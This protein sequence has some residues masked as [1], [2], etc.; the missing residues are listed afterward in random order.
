MYDCTMLQVITVRLLEHD[1][2]LAVLCSAVLLPQELMSSISQSAGE[3][4]PARALLHL[5]C[6]AQ[7]TSTDL[8]NRPIT[9]HYG[10]FLASFS[11]SRALFLVREVTQDYYSLPVTYNPPPFL[12]T[13]LS[14][15]WRN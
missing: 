7:L 11:P 15:G 14:M 5:P 4:G 9:L 13:H 2:A 1:T 3:G 8:A 10:L 12:Y 6:P